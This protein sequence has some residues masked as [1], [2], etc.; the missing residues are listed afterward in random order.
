MSPHEGLSGRPSR[1]ARERQG[2]SV[3]LLEFGC[4]ITPLLTIFKP[5]PLVSADELYW[6]VKIG[7]LDLNW[8]AQGVN[9]LSQQWKHI[10]EHHPGLLKVLI[11]FAALTLVDF[12]NKVLPIYHVDRS[13]IWAVTA[14]TVRAEAVTVQQR[15]GL[16]RVGER[17]FGRA[18]ERANL[19]PRANRTEQPFV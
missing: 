16:S 19:R 7:K 6:N 9:E 12:M 8:D 10:W 18:A 14:E 2:W 1:C 15:H 17:H 3:R 13:A 5:E 11:P 4:A